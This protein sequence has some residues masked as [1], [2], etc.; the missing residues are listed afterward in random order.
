[1]F[2]IFSSFQEKQEREEEERKKRIQL[3]VFV[4][5]SI[6]YTF[7]AKQSTD[8]TKRHLKVTKEAH[9]K[10]KS[11]VDVSWG[12]YTFRHTMSLVVD[13]SD[14]EM[15]SFSALEKVFICHKERKSS[16]NE[17]TNVNFSTVLAALKIPEKM[18][19][20]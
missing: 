3:Y 15:K 18:K 14:E 19:C 6:A 13:Y 16:S 2:S 4:L 11:K 17:R 5:R 10:M 12:Y 1:M 9:E 8:M 20:K 7:N